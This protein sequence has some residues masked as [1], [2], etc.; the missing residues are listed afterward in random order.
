MGKKLIGSKGGDFN[1]DKDI[2]S[3]LK[4]LN[5]EGKNKKKIIKNLIKLEDINDLIN[6]TKKGKIIGKSVIVY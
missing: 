1:P 6:E 4:I 5:L 2:S 3:Y